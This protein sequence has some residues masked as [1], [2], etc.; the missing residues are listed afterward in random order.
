MHLIIKKII[1]QRGV[2]VIYSKTLIS[3]M[4]D[5]GA[6]DDIE[7]RP[8]KKILR[9]VVTEDYSH[10]IA[11]IGEWN[12]EA[13]ALART[14]A[15][16]NKL[17]EDE[18]LYIFS[19][20]AY[21]LGWLKKA[22]QIPSEVKKIRQQEAQK[23]AKEAEAIQK[24][25]E[26]AIRLKAE[27]AARKKT[28]AA[29]NRA[30]EAERKMAEAER[31][32][33]EAE[34]ARRKAENDARLRLAEEERKKAEAEARI[35]EEEAKRRAEEEARKREEEAAR[36]KRIK[37][38]IFA[39]SAFLVIVCVVICIIKTCT[40]SGPANGNTKSG[41]TESVTASPKPSSSK[42]QKAQEPVTKPNSQQNQAKG[43]TLK[44]DYGIWKSKNVESP[45]TV[46]GRGTLRYT[47]Q[48]P[49]KGWPGKTAEPGDYI[50]GR[51][52]NGKPVNANWYDKNGNKK[53]YLGGS[54]E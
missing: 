2:D 39:A 23:K 33:K 49:I 53:D 24:A 34:A 19:C 15:Q 8:Y 52:E 1:K 20:L 30:K 10:K 45:K 3:C 44:L 22:P 36:K 16:R 12:A 32:V 25:S 37:R 28:E 7:M 48:T 17:Q 54:S 46:D 26:E 50:T 51:F 4:D 27:E 18:I 9:A 47:K 38:I 43:K 29:E 42:T 5:E 21:G 35:R 40:P 11:E 41:T 31:K 13:E 14:F 6:F